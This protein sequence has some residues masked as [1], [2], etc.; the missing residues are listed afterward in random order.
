MIHI[1]CEFH[2]KKVDLFKSYLTYQVSWTDGET[3]HCDYFAVCLLQENL[4]LQSFLLLLYF[5]FIQL[6]LLSVQVGWNTNDI[7]NLATLD[8]K[9]FDETLHDEY[10]YVDAI[11]VNSQQQYGFYH[12]LRLCLTDGATSVQH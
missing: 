9:E 2:E 8:L 6:S 3:A 4:A 1:W 12:S 7:D 5:F 10:I 11:Q